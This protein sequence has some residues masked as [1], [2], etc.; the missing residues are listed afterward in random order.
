[1]NA[2]HTHKIYVE[3]DPDPESPREFSTFTI[4]VRP[5]RY[6]CGDEEADETFDAGDASLYV[7]PVYAYIHGGV[8]LSC[9][10]FSDPWDSGCAGYMY[11]PRDQFADEAE[12]LACARGE[13]ETFNQYMDGDVWGYR[14]VKVDTCACCGGDEEEEIDG[15][16]GFYGSDPSENGMAEH[17]GD[18]AECAEIVELP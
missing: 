17:W 1:M 15:C 4:A 9:S 3:R 18:Y 11:A 12:A 10:P 8:A 7:F 13:L 14:V 5:N 6:F 16:W 2:K